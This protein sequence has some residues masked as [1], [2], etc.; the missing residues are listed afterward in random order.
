MN[1]K[2]YKNV[3]TFLCFYKI[4]TL[5]LQGEGGV[6]Y[7]MAHE[8]GTATHIKDNTMT[9]APT[10]NND[11]RKLFLLFALF[12][13][14]VINAQTG[15]WNNDKA[16]TRIGFEI[17]H[18]GVS[19]VSGYF[20]D[21]DIAVNAAGKKLQGT[22]IDVTIKA[23]SINTGIEARDNHLRSA[24]FF[25]ADKFPTMTFKSTRFVVLSKNKGKVYGN[26][27]IKGVTKPVVLNATLVG[28]ST[29]AQTGQK[30][31]GF[32]LT[33]SIKRSDYGFGPK[34]L[35]AAIGNL[36]GLIIDAEFSPASK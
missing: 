20:S 27:T 23:A 34:Y 7:V 18:G 2:R 5:S 28:Q 10:H 15:K 16:H 31:S 24:D 9:G 26:L 14:T 1:C 22:S 13:A 12:I 25:E 29:N 36:V 4:K 32:R 19:F 6:T 11:M 30:V 21:F 3:V 17:K 33:G 35:P 8:Q